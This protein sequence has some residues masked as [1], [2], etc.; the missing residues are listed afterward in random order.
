MLCKTYESSLLCMHLAVQAHTLGLGVLCLKVI[1]GP[2]SL[3]LHWVA[4]CFMKKKKDGFHVHYNISG[5][6]S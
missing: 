6:G 3:A 5:L 1:G 2:L 4:G